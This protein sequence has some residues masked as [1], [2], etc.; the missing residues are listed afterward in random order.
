VNKYCSL[1]N[2]LTD[3]LNSDSGIDLKNKMNSEINKINFCQGL[4]QPST[5]EKKVIQCLDDISKKCKLY[6][7]YR[8]AT[9]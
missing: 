3:H 5:G 7:F 8:C 4:R 9:S 1:Y 6:Y 2:K